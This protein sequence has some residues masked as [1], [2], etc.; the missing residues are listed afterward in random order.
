LILA[1]IPYARLDPGNALARAYLVEPERVLPLFARDYRDPRGLKRLAQQQ[2]ARPRP[3]LGAILSAYNR[4]VGGSVENAARLDDALCVVSGQQAGLLFGPAYTT[5]KLFTCINAARTLETELGTPVVPVFWVET[6]DHDWEEVNRFDLPGRRLKLDAAVEPGTPVAGV[7]ADAAPFLAAVR[8]ELGGEDAA[9]GIVA[10]ERGVARWHVRNLARLVEGSGVVFLEPHLLREPMRAFAGRIAAS[11]EAIDDSLRAD[12]GFPRRLEPPDGA[13]LFDAGDGRRRRAPRGAPVPFA[14][15]SDVAARVLVQNAALPALMAVC[16]PSEIQYWAQLNG[17]HEALG[18]PMPAVLPRNAATLVEAGPF[19]D[20]ARLGLGLEELVLGTTSPPEIPRD[21]DPVA[22]RLSGLATEARELLS[23]LEA[24]TLPLPANTE[25]P[26]RRT[27][28]RLEEDLARL[29]GRLDE[30]RADAEGVG[31][32]R[33]ERLL[34]ALRP[35]GT[36]QERVYSL[37]PFLARQGP[38]LA[39]RLREAFDPFEFGHYLVRA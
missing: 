7:E 16:G 29:A 1:T 39:A 5:Y 6:E 34:E 9:W 31:R 18:V 3:P 20:A 22:A 10:P 37:F 24:G 17:A 8:A 11:A 36:L 4:D 35:R 27:V 33:Y 13:Y 12:T 15:S 38:G 19:R 21:R 30:A 25:K 2:R 14:W 26:F 32:Q 23:A 28:T